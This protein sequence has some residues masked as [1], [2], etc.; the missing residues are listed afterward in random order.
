M[1]ND[2]LLILSRVAQD[3]QSGSVELTLRTLEQVLTTLPGLAPGQLESLPCLLAQ[4]QTVRPSMTVLE[5]A[6]QSCLDGLRSEGLANAGRVL[7]NVRSELKGATD[8]VA[9]QAVRLLAPGMTVMTHSRSSV[10]LAALKRAR[11]ERVNISVV[12][13]QGSP[14]NEGVSL[15]RELAAA[16]IPVTLITDAQM[17]LV[18]A[19]VDL[20][21]TGCDAWYQDGVFINKVGTFLL[22]LAARE[23]QKPFWVLADRF[24]VSS[25]AAGTAI[26]EE[27]PVSELAEG[28]LTVTEQ[29]NLGF[30][31]T[32]FEPIP[33]RL[34]TGRVG[35][36]ELYTC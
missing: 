1:N 10:V 19:E 25:R 21:L 32:Y 4:L 30:R 22:A 28:R 7:S 13:T 17:G 35:E 8:Q 26:L 29:A 2:F 36:Q 5:N 6:M 14:A 3:R 20:V 11:A 31:N 9:G 15:A 24:K 27:M 12:V 23:L 34:I 18:M 33:T 16:E